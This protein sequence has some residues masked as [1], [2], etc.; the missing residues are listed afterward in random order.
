MDQME[1]LFATL[2]AV[3][4]ICMLL[5]EVGLSDKADKTSEKTDKLVSLMVLGEYKLNL[6]EMMSGVPKLKPQY[7]W[8]IEV[9]GGSTLSPVITVSIIDTTNMMNKTEITTIQAH[10][11]Q[12]LHEYEFAYKP[13]YDAAREKSILPEY[14]MNRM[15]RNWY[16]HIQK[17]IISKTPVEYT[18]A[19]DAELS[20]FQF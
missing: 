5:I 13:W 14:N 15:M 16:H 11:N 10:H 4:L 20:N 2:I 19:D 6:T 7:L 1:V 3:G 8:D 9:Q 12:W 18:L 17:H